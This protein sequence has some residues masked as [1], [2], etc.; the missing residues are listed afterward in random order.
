M[1]AP[2]WTFAASAAAVFEV[3]GV[4]GRSGVCFSVT[5][6]STSG[7]G[8][9]LEGAVAMGAPAWHVTHE[10]RYGS[11]PSLRID[12]FC[13]GTVAAERMRTAGSSST[14]R[15]GV[16]DALRMVSFG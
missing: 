2:F 5:G 10:S 14:S 1:S 11:V 6:C 4:V 9:S 3:Y 15:L 7:K 8:P 16:D 12:V 13:F